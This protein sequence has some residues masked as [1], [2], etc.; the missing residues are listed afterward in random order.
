MK[1]ILIEKDKSFWERSVYNAATVFA[2]FNQFD[3]KGK[4]AFKT[5]RL[6]HFSQPYLLSFFQA[7]N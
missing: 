2:L 1:K 7:G 6:D 4:S 5:P 3:R